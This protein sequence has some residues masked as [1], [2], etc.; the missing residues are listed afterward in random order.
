MTR[1]SVEP[2]SGTRPILAFLGP[3]GT[4]SHQA[5][6]DRFAETVHYC[7][8]D[9]ISDAFHSVGPT[10]HLA[11]L[12]QENSIFGTV[13]ETY[14]LMRSPT[15]GESKW[16]RGAVTLSVQ[17]C[18]VV[19]CGKTLPEIKKV[20]SHEQALGQ[21][22]QF[23][24]THLPAAQP[25]FVAS[26]AA[27]AEAVSKQPD[28]T[29]SAAIC[30]KVC[31]QL[32]ADLEI[33][34]EGIQNERHNCTRFYIVA[35]HPSSPLPNTPHEGRGECNA[36]IRLEPQRPASSAAPQNSAETVTDLLAALRLPAVRI[37]RRPSSSSAQGEP[38]GSV[39]FVEV[40]DDN[41][42]ADASQPSSQH[43]SGDPGQLSSWTDKVRGA[44]AR[45][46]DCG[47]R[48]DLLGTW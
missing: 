10:T 5:A 38:F 14:D 30:S 28:A 11:L 13:T 23:I 34:H 22:Q 45:V 26:T 24:A 29:N 21:C 35:N 4:Y 42:R 27:A 36:L 33:L 2:T 46:A 43:P 16:I 41:E 39:Y 17:H 40:I 32:F 3:S 44:I 31:L 20:L 19:R 7:A 9:T 37:D 6:Y 25:V 48:A 8:Q 15:V 1:I 12:P 18:L 47:G